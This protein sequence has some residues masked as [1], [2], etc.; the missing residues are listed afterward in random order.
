MAQTKE[1]TVSRELAR[2]ITE[3][4]QKVADEVFAERGFAKPTVKTTFGDVYKVT[5]ESTPVA[6]GR[7]GVNMNSPEA[8]TFLAWPEEF[9]LTAED[10]GNKFRA[11][12]EEYVFIG[13]NR[14]ARSMP[15]M[16]VAVRGGRKVKLRDSAAAA[17]RLGRGK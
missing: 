8:L 6:E 4:F 12:G 11:G 9:D 15:L 13:V 7:N 2:E 17:I 10:L 3:R 5:I 14:R 16:A 1:H